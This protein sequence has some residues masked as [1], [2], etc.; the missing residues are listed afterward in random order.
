MVNCGLGGASVIAQKIVEQS[1]TIAKL[2]VRYRERGKGGVAGAIALAQTVA[3]EIHRNGSPEEQLRVKNQVTAFLR[4]LDRASLRD[5][6]NFHKVKGVLTSII[7][8]L[9]LL[10]YL[11]SVQAGGNAELTAF[12]SLDTTIEVDLTKWLELAFKVLSVA[13]S[14]PEE[15]SIKM[16]SVSCALALTTGRSPSQIHCSGRFE[17]IGEYALKFEDVIDGTIVEIPTLVPAKLVVSGIDWLEKRGKRVNAHKHKPTLVNAKWG[18][19]LSK[20]AREK[21]A[22]VPDNQWQKISV[23]ERWTYIKLNL[24]YHAVCLKSFHTAIS[25]PLSSQYDPQILN[26]VLEKPDLK[27]SVLL[28]KIRIAPNSLTQ[29]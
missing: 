1:E 29:I 24:L 21:W 28:S 3:A 10:F 14:E 23:A 15:Q 27:T 16:E 8:T 4:G 13:Q 20:E 26:F 12:S 22:I 19:L 11:T 7:K 17:A 9:D 18:K 2:P 5:P 25:D 6:D